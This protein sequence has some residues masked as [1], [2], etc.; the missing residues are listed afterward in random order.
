MTGVCGYFTL[1]DAGRQQWHIAFRNPWAFAPL[2]LKVRDDTEWAPKTAKD[3]YDSMD[4]SKWSN[5][6]TYSYRITVHDMPLMPD[7]TRARLPAV[8]TAYIEFF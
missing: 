2:Q 7:R 8:P 3:L 6:E 5:E 4:G 1:V